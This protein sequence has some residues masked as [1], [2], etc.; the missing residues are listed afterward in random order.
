MCEAVGSSD[1]CEC[2]NECCPRRHFYGELRYKAGPLYK[3]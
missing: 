2:V 3:C 1:V